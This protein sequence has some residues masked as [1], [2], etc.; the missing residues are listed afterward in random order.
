[1]S[2]FVNA[3]VLSYFAQNL[4]SS[5]S[6]N[7]ILVSFLF[8]Q[9]FHVHEIVVA[10]ITNQNFRSILTA[11]VTPE[12]SFFPTAF[13]QFFHKN[14]PRLSPRPAPVGKT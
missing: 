10:E 13:A 14:R 2:D 3:F 6:H 12:L 1:M 4:T 9:L 5:S 8:Q 7:Y 11:K